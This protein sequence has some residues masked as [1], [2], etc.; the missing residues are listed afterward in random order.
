M[1]RGLYLAFIFG[2]AIIFLPLILVIAII[3]IGL[4]GFPVFY[5]QKRMGLE[6][7]PFTLYKFRTMH[8]GAEK[9]QKN[10][11]KFNEAVGPIFKIRNDPRFTSFGKFLSHT[12][13]D[14]LPQLLNV[15]KGGMA[16]I[17]PRPLPVDEAKKLKSWQKKRSDIKPGII[18][19]WIIDGY[20]SRSFDEWMRSDIDYV[21]AKSF[22]YDLKLTLRTAQLMLKL[23]FL[24]LG[25]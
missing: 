19:P 25:G 13:L 3:N 5:K 16:L 17:G 23:L 8:A 9:L 1:T 6:G 4:S 22:S 11:R 14:E 24:E 7:K 20:H 12:G 18:S 15:L 10:Y 21:K 2:L